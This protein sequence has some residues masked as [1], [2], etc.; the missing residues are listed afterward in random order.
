MLGRWVHTQCQS[1]RFDAL[2]FSQVPS[3]SSVPNKPQHRCISLEKFKDDKNINDPWKY[4]GFRGRE[5]RETGGL[6]LDVSLAGQ[7]DQLLCIPETLISTTIL[8]RAHTDSGLGAR[9]WSQA[10]GGLIPVLP[11]TSGV[12]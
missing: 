8:T 6:G 1:L 4:I 11:G 3:N 9:L 5:K 10:A 7:R 2:E 12:T